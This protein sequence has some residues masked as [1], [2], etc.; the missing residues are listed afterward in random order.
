MELFTGLILVNADGLKVISC[1]CQRLFGTSLL[2]LVIPEWQVVIWGFARHWTR[3]VA[4]RIG[5]VGEA[6]LDDIVVGV[7]H[8]IRTIGVSCH[9]LH[10]FSRL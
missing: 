8:V 3:C 4:E 7:D 6:M 2:L 9:G 10:L 5:L 1:Y